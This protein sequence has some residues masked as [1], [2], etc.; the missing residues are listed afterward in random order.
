MCKPNVS[1]RARWSLAEVRGGWAAEEEEEREIRVCLLH[2]WWLVSQKLDG[3]RRNQ[4]ERIPSACGRRD[5]CVLG[6]GGLGFEC[7]RRASA[8]AAPAFERA[9]P[10]GRGPRRA[11]SLS[12][13]PCCHYLLAP[14]QA[15]L[16]PGPILA[17][18]SMTGQIDMQCHCLLDMTLEYKTVSILGARPRA[19]STAPLT[20]FCARPPRHAIGAPGSVLHC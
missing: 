2:I 16:T 14:A 20:L 15:P 1:R 19:A 17:H 3:A 6:N 9:A 11:H 12:S 10:A 5:V 4:I 13:T 8:W 18:S 7:T